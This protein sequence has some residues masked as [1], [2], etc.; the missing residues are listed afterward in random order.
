MSGPAYPPARPTSR[1]VAAALAAFKP[2]DR[3]ADGAPIER[4]CAVRGCD[5]YAGF[6]FGCFP[7]Q[8]IPGTWYCLA[9]KPVRGEV[10]A[11]LP[12]VRP[13]VASPQGKL[14]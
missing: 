13:S 5:A 1:Q 2:I 3:T 4:R 14:L 10:R 7:G 11:P 12:A 8:G 9:H 6:G